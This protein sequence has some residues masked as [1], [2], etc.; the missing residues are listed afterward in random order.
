MTM[1]DGMRW[2]TSVAA[3]L[4]TWAVVGWVLLSVI[5]GALNVTVGV[6]ELNLLIGGSALIGVVV[7]IMLFRRLGKNREFARQ[8]GSKDVPPKN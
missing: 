7:G 4:F 1:T 3:A 6:N 2:I 5:A 8:R